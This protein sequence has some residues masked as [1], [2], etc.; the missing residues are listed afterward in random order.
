M[1]D[2]PTVAVLD[3]GSGN[4]RSVVRAVE[5]AGAEVE[6]TSDFEACL[7]ADGLLVPGVGA[8]A[9]CMAGL[10]EVKGERIIDEHER[11]TSDHIDK[12][13][14]LVLHQNQERQRDPY[15]PTLQTVGRFVISGIMVAML[16][17]FLG[18]FR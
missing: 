4:L 12:L 17:A 6:L 14:S 3:Y 5:R 10:R 1:S 13:R 11:V 2:R 8:Y 15:L 9:A 7:A 18:L 16:F